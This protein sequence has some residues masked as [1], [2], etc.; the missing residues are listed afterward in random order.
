MGGLGCCQMAIG[1]SQ[2]AAFKSQRAEVVEAEKVI[3][4]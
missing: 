4:G 2:I 3:K 1:G